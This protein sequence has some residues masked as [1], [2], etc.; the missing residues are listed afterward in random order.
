MLEEIWAVC[1]S[2][3]LAVVPG[4][5][6]LAAARQRGWVLVASP[7][8]TYGIVTIGGALASWTGLSWSVLTL[9]LT[10]VLW[11][12]VAF[13]L[14]TFVPRVGRAVVDDDLYAD[15][16]LDVTGEHAEA[17][18]PLARRLTWRAHA[19]VAACAAF[20]GLFGA[21]VLRRGMGSLN[22]VVQDWDGVFH[23]AV[24]R[25]IA[26]T[27]DLSQSSIAQLN[28]RETVETFF[29]PSS[30]HGLAAL[31][32]DLG[33]D[34][35]PRLLNA[36]S[37]MMPILLAFGIA[38]LVLRVTRNPVA[39]G[40]SA[41]L[42][43]MPSALVFD[44]LWRGPL[45]PFAVGLAMVPA[46]VLLFD[47][48]LTLRSTGLVVATGLAA[49]GVVGV[50]PSGVYTAFIFLVP[51]ILQRWMTHRRLVVGDLLTIVATGFVAAL[52]AAPSLLTAISAST[53]A[54]QDWPAVE[55]AGQAV[56]EALL[57]NHARSGPQWA[58][59]LLAVVGVLSFRKMRSMW[60]F[61]VAGILSLGLFVLAAAYDTP[62]GEDLTA[63]W[64]NDRWRFAA[65]VAMFVAVA[66]GVGVAAI[67]ERVPR[68]VSG[69]TPVGLKVATGGVV[70]V[71]VYA[72]SML[73][74][75]G[76]AAQNADRMY[77]NFQSGAVIGDDDLALWAKAAEIVPEGQMVLNDPTDGSTWMLATEGLRPFFGGIT[78]AIPNQAGLSET[79][80]ALLFHLSDI[81]T[82]QEV[83]DIVDEYGIEYVIVGE[84]WIHGMS[85]AAGFIGI[86]DNPA[87]ELV[88]QVG[89]AQLFRIVG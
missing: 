89:G 53:G 48:T 40:A 50:H 8:V 25:W 26:E 76:Y 11:A 15:D 7:L 67:V 83:R 82:D 59:V 51:W 68:W 10:T 69:R 35:V 36:G 62:T 58:I 20:G 39:A 37:L 87:F 84:G 80:E 21:Y 63:P 34:S 52:V 3:L 17:P 16:E 72:F 49:G 4:A 31:G 19:L 41:I 79:Q 61:W 85:R 5:A 27:G 77:W 14:S 65:M 42:V 46:L 9:A 57:L 74:H 33:V 1:A 54:R 86:E 66:A 2:L 6:V 18:V 47:R 29:Y 71:L 78:L 75:A 70:V 23:A 45:I 73:S 24:V 60:W 30:W 38:G 88:E 22:A 64:W 55:T 12:A 28:N 81:A 13:V 44:T 32:W 56:G 43:T